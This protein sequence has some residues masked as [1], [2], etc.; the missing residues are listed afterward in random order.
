[1]HVVRR[2]LVGPP[3]CSGLRVQGHHTRCMEVVAF[4]VISVEVRARITDCPV[5]QSEAGIVGA[6]QPGCAAAMV[7]RIP[8]PG[9]RAL[10][11]SEWNRVE[12]PGTLAARDLV[13][14]HKSARALLATG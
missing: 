8:N 2:E 5:H 7:D 1:M 12:S 3:Q 10:L 6:R 4:T 11:A 14:I 13:G 9:F